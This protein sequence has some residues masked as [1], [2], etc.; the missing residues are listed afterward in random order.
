MHG[1]ELTAPDGFA[2][3][4][5]TV[6]WIQEDASQSPWGLAPFTTFSFDECNAA[7]IYGN[8]RNL[9]GSENWVISPSYDTLCYPSPITLESVQINY[10]GWKV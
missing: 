10:S 8:R 9:A 5:S 7:D 6:E 3:C 4:G 2:L 1:L